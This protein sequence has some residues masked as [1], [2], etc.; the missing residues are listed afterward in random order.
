MSI[1]IV[2][3]GA[4]DL[5][6]ISFAAVNELKKDKKIY[7]RTDNHPIVEYL[8][9]E[10]TSFDEYYDRLENFEEVYEAISEKIVE[11]GKK[12]DI[13]YA[14]P[15]H[16]RVAEKTVSLIEKYAKLENIELEIIASMSFIDAMYNYLGFDPSD[17]FTLIDAFEVRR[18]NLD[19][20]SNIIITQVYDRYIASNVKLK[21]MD[22]YDDEQDVWLV[23]SAGIKN[24]EYKKKVHL[25]DLDSI[26]N[27]F[28]HLT[29]LYIPK[30][31]KKRFM[32][33]EDLIEIT[34]KLRSE[35]GCPWDK[36][37]SHGSLKRYIVEEAYELVEAIE[38]DDI[39]GI[40]EELGDILYQVTI[41]SQIGIEEGYFDIY[42]VSNAISKKMIDR[43]AHVFDKENADNSLTWE[44]K[45]MIEKNETKITESIKRTVKSLPGLMKA[46]K[47]QDKAAKVGFDWDSIEPVFDKVL[48]EYNEFLVEYKNFDKQKMKNEFGDLLFSLVNLARFLKIDPEEAIQLTNHK[49]ISRFEYV[50]NAILE[51]GKTFEDVDLNTMDIYW[52]E[53]KKIDVCK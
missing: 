36:E 9:I 43:H 15:G 17:G 42:E 53:A 5:S 27:E 49:F 3:L 19:S 50:E 12:E 47:I 21:L 24:L 35:D 30:S 39:D 8:N 40:I 25:Y 16:P 28:D 46:E 51:S 26:K 33:I 44:E 7:L 29:S 41:H 34:K 18:K 1:T 13:I 11:E 52:N 23:K 4:G 6:Q 10:Y 31:D 14:V 2:G 37:Q 32:D 45:K 20:E 48:E 38:E 22:Y